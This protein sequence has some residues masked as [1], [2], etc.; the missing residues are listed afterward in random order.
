MYVKCEKL[1]FAF[2][3][4]IVAIIM[5]RQKNLNDTFC[6]ERNICFSE[7]YDVLLRV[8]N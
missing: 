1:R 8:I 7:K 2:K 5:S 4:H 3:N 6:C